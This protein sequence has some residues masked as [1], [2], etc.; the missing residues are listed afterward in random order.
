MHLNLEDIA[1]LAGVSRSTVSRVVNDHPNVSERTRKKVLQVIEEQNYRPNL[2][3]RAL[4]TQHT[5]ILSLVIP[6]S[7]NAS[8]PFFSALIEGILSKADECNYAVMLWMNKS[9]EHKLRFCSRILSNSLFDGLIITSM[10][11]S[12]PIIPRLANARF[13]FVVIGVPPFEGLS[14]IDV[15]HAQGAQVAV[16]HLIRLGW[17]RIGTITG[18]LDMGEG[19]DRLRG[20]RAAL[21]RAGRTVD[22]NLI[23]TGNFDEASGYMGMITLLRRGVDAV[24]AAN[25]MMALG[26]LRAIRDQGA[27]VPEDIG[28]VGFDDIPLAASTM[29]SLTTIRQPIEQLGKMGVQVLVDLLRERPAQPVQILLPTQLIVRETCGATR[30]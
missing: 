14:Y 30:L 24:F 15:D 23:V 11:E 17:K 22:E 21:E 3:A 28:V 27:R 2:A 6:K 8:D 25:D 1:Q 26:A 12:E 7:V 16:S 19:K 9:E 10:T 29:P 13:P 18:P 20:Y 5:Q 4:V